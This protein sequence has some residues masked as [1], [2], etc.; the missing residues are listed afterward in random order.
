LK[1][2]LQAFSSVGCVVVNLAFRS[3][4]CDAQS[5]HVHVARGNFADMTFFP[6]GLT[7]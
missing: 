5:L 6:Y 7:E 2:T 3:Y 1:S 4:K